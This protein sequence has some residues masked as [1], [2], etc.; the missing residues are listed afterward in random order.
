[1]RTASSLG[2][3]APE[4]QGQETGHCAICYAA[5]CAKSFQLHL[6]LCDPMDRSPPGSSVRGIL[7]VRI[8]EWVPS[9]SPE[10]LP[11]LRTEL[12]SP[13]FPA[14]AGRFFTTEPL[15][16]PIGPL[17]CHRSCRETDPGVMDCAHLS[18]VVNSVS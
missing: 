8:L 18:R 17:V 3:I 10:D 6:S 5:P 7:Q 11:D 15:A 13:V 4:I 2:V 1:M 9:L 12:A 16:K 14:L